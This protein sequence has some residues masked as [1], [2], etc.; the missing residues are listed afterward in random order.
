[1]PSTMAGVPKRL[2]GAMERKR[3]QASDLA[4][5][6]GVGADVIS[7]IIS[8]ER[9]SGSQAATFVRLATALEVPVGWLLT[10]EGPKSLLLIQA[11]NGGVAAAKP[12]ELDGAKPRRLD[13]DRPQ[14][15]RAV[16]ERKVPNRRRKKK[17]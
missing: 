6:S 11:D 9:L 5:A 8:G 7:R 16:H 2:E 14:R 10:G 15:A 4:A 12:P 13:E 17:P 1:M 3:W